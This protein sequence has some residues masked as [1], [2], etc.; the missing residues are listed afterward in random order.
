MWSERTAEEIICS[1]YRSACSG[2]SSGG[3]LEPKLFYVHGE[4]Q[5][6]MVKLHKSNPL[7][8]ILCFLN[9]KPRSKNHRVASLLWSKSTHIHPAGDVTRGSVVPRFGTVKIGD[10]ENWC[11]GC[12]DKNRLKRQKNPV[13][14][15]L[16]REP[17]KS[18]V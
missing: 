4:F 15:F 8:L 2:G 9:L 1:A 5:E 11:R 7:L 18:G 16:S 13:R 6:K 3:P 14:L 12:R 10:A 17:F